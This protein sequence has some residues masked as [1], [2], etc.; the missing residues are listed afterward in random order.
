MIIGFIN[1]LYQIKIKRFLAFSSIFSI[2]LLLINFCD[3]SF[4]SYI[5]AIIYIITYLMTLIIIFYFI[6]YFRL[7]NFKEMYYIFEFDNFKNNVFLI[8]FISIILF[9]FA[10]IPP[11]MNFF[12]KFFVFFTLMNIIIILFYLLYF[13]SMFFLVFIIYV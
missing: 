11:L 2:G 5:S 12:G 13:F 3:N 8:F 9:S 6:L 10:G 7:F 4:D 1:A